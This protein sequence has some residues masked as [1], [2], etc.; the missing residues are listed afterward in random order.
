MKLNKTLVLPLAALLVV[1][2]AGVVLATTGSPSSGGTDGVVPA[3]ASPS[4]SPSAGTKTGM[5]DTLLSDVLDQLVSKGT[6]TAAQKTAILDALTAERQARITQ[7]QQERQQLRDFLSD[8]V[9]TQD[10]LNKLPAD[11][12]LRQLT[13]LMA[14]G[15]ITID[16]LRSLG[17]GFLGELGGLG[18][19]GRGFGHGMGP[20]GGMWGP[21][22]ASP[23]PSTGTSG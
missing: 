17:R 9:I 7:R 18:I 14:D 8:G 20:G 10:E 2:A 21:P 5:N 12:P 3:A 23:S 4:P 19:G 11:S 1:G 22:N 16:E 13:T 15:K 6:I